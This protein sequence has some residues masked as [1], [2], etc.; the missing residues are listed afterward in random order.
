M[1]GDCASALSYAPF[2]CMEWSYA[3]VSLRGVFAREFAGCGK[4]HDG[5]WLVVCGVFAVACVKRQ[6]LEWSS[7]KPFFFC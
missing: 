7:W 2:R 1:D 6:W 3:L 4:W 5:A